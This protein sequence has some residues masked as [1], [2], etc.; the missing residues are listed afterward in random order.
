M[1]AAV[2]SECPTPL[3]AALISAH[4]ATIELSAIKPKD[5]RSSGVTLPPNHRTSPYAMK[6]MVKFLKMVYTGTDK[7]CRALV[8]V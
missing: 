6:T 5:S 4:A 1:A 8:L 2:S 3:R 7:Y